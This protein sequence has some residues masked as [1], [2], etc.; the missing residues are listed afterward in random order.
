[1]PNAVNAYYYWDSPLKRE[2]HQIPPSRISLR[3]S[4]PVRGDMFI[5]T[6]ITKHIS[7]S[8]GAVYE[9]AVRNTYRTYGAWVSC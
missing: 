6:D 1:M 8:V 9:I 3:V 5:E 4:N 7:S 2:H